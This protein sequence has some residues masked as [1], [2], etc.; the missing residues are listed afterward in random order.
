MLGNSLQNLSNEIYSKS[1][2]FILELIQNADD[3]LYSE[4]PT[5]AFELG[6]AR[7]LVLNNELGF[8]AKNVDALCNIG[9]SSKKTK[10]T[11][12]G[13]VG[14]IGEK[15]IG[16]KS[17][18]VVSNCVEI[19]SNGYHF[20]FDVSKRGPLGMILP[21][22]LH[23]GC[24]VGQDSRSLASPNFPHLRQYLPTDGKTK[25]PTDWKTKIV[26]PLKG[27]NQELR[28]KLAFQLSQLSPNLLLF[29]QRLRTMLVHDTVEKSVYLFSREHQS[30]AE[31]NFSL[32]TL[33]PNTSVELVKLTSISLQY[34]D[35]DELDSAPL[36]TA[37]TQKNPDETWM[38]IR[39]RLKPPTGLERKGEIVKLTELALAFP[40][41][42]QSHSGQ[43]SSERLPQQNVFSFLPVASY[44]FRFVVQADF[45]LVASRDSIRVVV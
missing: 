43:P 1:T 36:S 44:G 32:P 23:G 11:Q 7:M 41:D 3:N 34:D 17:V 39:R 25:K 12:N 37:T 42:K 14:F 18:F 30:P 40:L 27:P 31:L 38:V 20:C 13:T 35:E 28:D 4:I 24:T 29:L 10:V 6:A 2:H 26:L 33:D 5:L 15:G 9:N 16:F 45:L 22:W 21:D 8:V 19:H